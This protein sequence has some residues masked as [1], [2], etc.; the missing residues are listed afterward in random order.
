MKVILLNGSPNQYGCTYTA[1]HEIE[2]TLNYFKIDTEIIW[3]GKKSVQGCIACFQCTKR[4]KCVF[5]DIVNELALKIKESDALIVGSPVYYSNPNGSLLALLDRL[6]LSSKESLYAKL[7]ASV[8][9]AR[10]GGC[11]FAFDAINKFFT[12]NCMHIVSSQYWN[13]V[14]GNTPEE[15]KQDLEGMQTMRTLAKQM[16]WLLNCIDVARQNGVYPPQQ[17]DTILTNFIK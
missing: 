13:Q 4:H 2:E 7:G 15:V 17:E 10:R 6:A 11:S 9:S 8:V 12:M 3:I 1:L 14:H 16:A 5:D